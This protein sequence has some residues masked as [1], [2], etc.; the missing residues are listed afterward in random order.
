MP[1][2]LIYNIE[3]SSASTLLSRT[4][5]DS[6]IRAHRI[7]LQIFDPFN[8]SPEKPLHV[9]R[10]YLKCLRSLL[11][12]L[13]PILTVDFCLQWE[14]LA[15]VQKNGSCD[16]SVTH[17]RLV[18]VDVRRA[19]WAVIAVYRLARVTCV[20]VGFDL[21]L[22]DFQVRERDKGVQSEGSA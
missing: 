17:D 4:S 15:P 6:T 16:D 1:L 20:V 21:A 8:L 13:Q 14:I 11:F 22:G 3:L 12:P 18:M 9:R 2:G 19:I 10:Q 5:R 7:P